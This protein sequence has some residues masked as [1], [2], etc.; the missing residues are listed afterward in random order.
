MSKEHNQFNPD[1]FVLD[2]YAI[3]VELD[4][5][6]ASLVANAVYDR[7]NQRKYL[8]NSWFGDTPVTVHVDQ[9]GSS[10]GPLND[11]HHDSETKKT[12][13]HLYLPGEAAKATPNQTFAVETQRAL[14]TDER[15]SRMSVRGTA[16]AALFMPGLFLGFAGYGVD[17]EIVDPS[18]NS[19]GLLAAGISVGAM[20]LLVSGPAI[21]QNL[22]RRTITN[23]NLNR[24]H[25]S[26]AAAHVAKL[27]LPPVV[28]F[29]S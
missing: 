28:S 18:R 22:Y 14:D 13:Y 12:G 7:N 8:N 21:T 25:L 17:R 23:P 9:D 19:N 27:G 3:G 29:A 10:H 4:Q 6:I 20:G 2:P 26:R 15:L 24:P 11:L 16:L 1:Q 5:E